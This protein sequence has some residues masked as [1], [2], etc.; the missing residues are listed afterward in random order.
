MEKSGYIEIRIQGTKG[1]KELSP[2]NY[3]ISEIIALLHNTENL[4]FPSDKKHRPPITYSLESGSVRNILKTSLQV[5]IGFNALL[6]QINETQSIEFLDYRTAK[7][8]EVFQEMA[9]KNNYVVEI[10][11]SLEKSNK[12]HV[13]INTEFYKS[14]SVW[15][16]TELY[17]YGEIVDMGG[18]NKSNIHLSTEEFGTVL[19]NTPKEILKSY[20]ENYLYKRYGIRAIGKQNIETGE[21]DKTSLNFKEII[22]Y[23]T[24]YDERYLFRLIKKAKQSWTEIA[25]IDEWLRELR[26]G[27]NA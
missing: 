4:L 27:Y 2:D 1:Q 10:S 9:V 6:Y 26:G 24:S 3:D 23:P 13:A 17:L 14:E 22:F 25:D 15:V 7:A 5:V 8:F 11:T 12:L 20:D 16:E 18:K 21:I 19:I